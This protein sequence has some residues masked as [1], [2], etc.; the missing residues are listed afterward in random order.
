MSG[1][2]AFCSGVCPGRFILAEV[3]PG[4]I[5]DAGINLMYIGIGSFSSFSWRECF[6]CFKTL[7]L[8]KKR[9]GKTPI[10]IYMRFI[11]ASRINPG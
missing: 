1:P 9:M 8:N 4:F 6:N 3:Y 2:V 5:L 11:P 7:F 10:P